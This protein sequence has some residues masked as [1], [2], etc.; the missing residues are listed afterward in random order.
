MVA[1]QSITA[2]RDYRASDR[3]DMEPQTHVEI[4]MRKLSD[5]FAKF[6]FPSL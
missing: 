4:N 1:H 3:E 6:N 2:I 5:G